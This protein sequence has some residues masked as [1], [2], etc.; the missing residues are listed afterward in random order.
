MK[1]TR[2]DI[3][4]IGHAEAGSALQL[5]L[6]SMGLPATF[7]GFPSPAEEYVE[8]TLDLNAYLIANPPATVLAR[9]SGDSLIDAGIF[10]GDIAIIDR[11]LEA[12]HMDKVVAIF[13]GEMTLKVLS[14]HPWQLQPRNSQQS[15]IDIQEEDDLQVFGVLTGIVRKYK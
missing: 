8:S 3:E 7:T 13:N 4:I 14:T 12:V 9:V 1:I 6:V 15:P 11:S 2:S 5:P 10:P